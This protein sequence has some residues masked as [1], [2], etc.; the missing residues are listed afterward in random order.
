MQNRY[1]PDF[2]FGIEST[3]SKVVRVGSEIPAPLPPRYVCPRFLSVSPAACFHANGD[4][5]PQILDDLQLSYIRPFD[6]KVVA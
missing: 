5:V 1:F 6:D 3:G 2:S 4:V